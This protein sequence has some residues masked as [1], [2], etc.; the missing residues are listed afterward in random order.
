MPLSKTYGIPNT[1]SPY[2]TTLDDPDVVYIGLLI[3]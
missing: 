2:D 1:L 3:N